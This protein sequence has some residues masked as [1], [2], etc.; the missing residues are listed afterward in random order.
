MIFTNKMFYHF[1]SFLTI[2]E[3]SHYNEWPPVLL[4]QTCQLILPVP[5]H[6]KSHQPSLIHVRMYVYSITYHLILITSPAAILN[7]PINSFCPLDTTMVLTLYD[8]HSI[9]PPAPPL[10][11]LPVSQPPWWHFSETLMW[12]HLY[13]VFTLLSSD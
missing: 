1:V 6:T 8:Y 7:L 4:Q 3:A 11:P 10:L 9:F 13:H 2:L 12:C 5:I